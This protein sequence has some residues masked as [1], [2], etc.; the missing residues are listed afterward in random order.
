MSVDLTNLSDADC[1]EQRKLRIL[2]P[3]YESQILGW[4]TFASS[5]AAM[6]QLNFALRD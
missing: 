2:E 6:S 3:G 4:L 1:V 5:K